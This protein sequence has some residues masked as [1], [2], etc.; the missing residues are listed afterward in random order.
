VDLWLND[1]QVAL[2]DAVASVCKQLFTSEQV[3]A[4]QSTAGVDRAS[5]SALADIG[6]FSLRLPEPD[7]AGL[8]TAE[9]VLALEQLARWFVPGPLVA[10]VLA[11]GLVDGVADGSVVVGLIDRDEDPLLAENLDALDLLLVLDDSG[12]VAVERSAVTATAVPDPADPLTPVHHVTA[13]GEGRSLGGRELAA[14]WRTEGAVLT[15]GLQIGLAQRALDQ[16]VTYARQRE[17]F[18]QPIG[19]FQAVKHLLADALAR[20]EIARSAVYAAAVTIDDPE[21]GDV[22]R[23]ASAAKLL[24]DE[25]AVGNG[26]TGVQVHGGMGFTWEVDAHLPLR[27]AWVYA[28]HFGTADDHAE[29]LAEMA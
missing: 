8:G 11:A 26:R 18:G 4:L 10:N 9:A 20:V 27:R 28:T 6:L 29:L 16:A 5:W 7:G 2:Q 15:S 12:V 23:R 24:A 21:V 25:A 14:R 3:R 13:I 17:Q 1:E 19:Q 22:A